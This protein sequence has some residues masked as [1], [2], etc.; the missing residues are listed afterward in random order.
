M[1]LGHCEQNQ[2]HYDG[3]RDL[4]KADYTNPPQ[5]DAAWIGTWI[6]VNPLLKRAP[7]PTPGIVLSVPRSRT[8]LPRNRCS[9]GHNV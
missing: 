2:D 9:W 7:D 6:I 5:H 3:Q 4:Y 1:A 8:P